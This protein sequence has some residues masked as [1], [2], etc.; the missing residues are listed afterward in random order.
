[1]EINQIVPIMKNI[2]SLAEGVTLKPALAL[3][4]LLLTVVLSRFSMFLVI[5]SVLLLPLT[6]VNSRVWVAEF[7][8]LGSHHANMSV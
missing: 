4:N 8:L 6:Y 2:E 1:M 5:M 3:N 7:H